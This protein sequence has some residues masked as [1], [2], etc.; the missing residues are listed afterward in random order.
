MAAVKSGGDICRVSADPSR[1]QGIGKCALVGL[2]SEEAASDE[3]V[4]VHRW[5]VAVRDSIASAEFHASAIC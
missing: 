5:A 4:V 2:K 1:F 3:A